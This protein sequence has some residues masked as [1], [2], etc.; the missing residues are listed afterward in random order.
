VHEYHYEFEA[1][2]FVQA[3]LSDPRRVAQY[4]APRKA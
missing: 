1:L 2:D 3:Q 4:L